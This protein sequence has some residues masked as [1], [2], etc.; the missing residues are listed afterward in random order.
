M[1]GYNP[2]TGG[3]RQE[4]LRDSL[5]DPS[6]PRDEL[7]VLWKILPWKLKWKMREEEAQSQPLTSIC[8]HT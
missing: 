4:D 1:Q 2:S 8:A 6:I 7:W 5:A 3:Q